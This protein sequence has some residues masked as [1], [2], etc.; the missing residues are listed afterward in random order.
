[1]KTNK[2]RRQLFSILLVAV[3]WFG[4]FPLTVHAWGAKGHHIIAQIASSRLSSRARKGVSDLLQGQSLEAASTWADLKRSSQTFHFVSIT[5]DSKGYD[6]SSQCPQDN[7]LIEKIRSYRDIVKDPKE[8][9][10]R[11]AEALKYILHLVGDLH[12]PFH[13]IDRNGNNV[14]VTFDKRPTNLHKVWDMDIIEKANLTAETYARQ[15]DDNEGVQQKSYN[16]ARGTL[17][18][19]A[20]ES[21]GIARTA[22]VDRGELGDTY[23][24]DHKE[25]VERQLYR[26]GV[27]LANI[28]NDIF[29]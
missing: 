22:Y 8:T 3:I 19:W 11:R 18:D 23:Y 28:L 17:V 14:R 9:A 2:L 15:I 4:V 24:R 10:A 29:R 16:I 21:H 25:V 7:C 5:F 20:L 12:Q 1:M 26:A 27:R 13:C 6:Q